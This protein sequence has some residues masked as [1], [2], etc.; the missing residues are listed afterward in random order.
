M[1]AIKDMK[2]PKSCAECS[3]VVDDMCG[4][5]T[6]ILLCD[7]WGDNENHRAENCPLT[8]IIT[9]KDCVKGHKY[10]KVNECYC[11][12][13]REDVDTDFYCAEAKRRE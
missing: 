6:C 5:A 7:E 9:C 10:Q 12:Y 3:F 8:E 11:D 4:G 2:M 13:L 1:V